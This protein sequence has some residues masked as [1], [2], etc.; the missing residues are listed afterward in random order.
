[1]P[2][3][4]PIIGLPDYKLIS[5]R[6]YAGVE[7]HAEYI[8]QRSCPF[9]QGQN[10]RKKDTLLRRLKHHSRGIDRTFLILKCHKFKCRNCRRYF[11]DRLPGIQKRMQSTEPFRDEM[12]LKH[13]QG[14]ARSVT[15]KALGVSASTVE[16]AYKS[17]LRRKESH[18]KSAM[19]PRVLGIDEKHFTKKKGY[20]TT[21]CDLKRRKVFDVTLGR[22]ELS[23]Q[24][25][26]GKLSGK[27]NCRVVVMDL[28]ETYRSI[29][30]KHFSSAMIV[31]DRFHVVKLVNHH[32]LKTWSDID[33][34]GRKNRG[35][36][37]LMRRHHENL[38]PEQVPKLQRYLDQHP[39][40]REIY[41]FKQ[42]LMKIIKVRIYSK[43]EA[44]RMIPL[45]LDCIRSLKE[46]GLKHMKVLGETLESWQEEI[47]RMWRF[48]RTNSITEGLHN[49]MEEIIRRAYGFRNF[50]NFRLR[51]KEY[52]S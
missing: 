9:C 40:M 26:L 5:V 11:N 6:E 34:V 27:S 7:Y 23:L 21:F 13:H 47:V 12:S 3:Y 52:C 51:V 43:D 15:T 10:L 8:G 2:H 16:R 24:S 37:S 30:N 33:E 1:M 39:A 25:Y 32:F 42:Y 36:L 17:Y 20:L 4:E 38:K 45:F 31:A 29:A 35:L 41:N 22:S 18:R 28:S 46:S 14:M 44:R 50:E 48:S 49:R 19:C